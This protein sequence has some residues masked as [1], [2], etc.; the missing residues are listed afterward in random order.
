[1]DDVEFA[2]T[3]LDRYSRAQEVLDNQS[4]LLRDQAAQRVYD[5]GEQAVAWFTVVSADP[6]RV[7]SLEDTGVL[8]ALSAVCEAHEGATVHTIKNQG[9]RWRAE[10]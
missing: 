3:L 5:I 2:L 7:A 4:S 8:E 10:I 9:I 1:M 6:V